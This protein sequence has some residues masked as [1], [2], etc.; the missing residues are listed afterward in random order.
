ML[1]SQADTGST[2]ISQL[3]KRQRLLKRKQALWTARSSRDVE[4]RE[5][6]TYL[7]PRL[8]RFNLEHEQR[9]SSK[10]SLYKQILDSS[11]TRGHRTLAAGLMAGVSS[12]ARP[13]VRL[14]IG[15]KQLAEFGPV[16][17]WLKDVTSLMLAIFA[18][19]NTYRSM[20]SIYEELAAFGTG[21]DLIVDDFEDVLRHHPM[22]A[23][24]YALATDNRGAVSTFV[25]EMAMSV[26]QMVEEFGLAKCSMTVRNAYAAGNYDTLVPVYHMVEPRKDR[27]VRKRD[28]LNM[29]FASIY[30]EAGGDD[31]G[32]TL[33]EGG[34]N[35]FPGLAPRWVV[36][37]TDTWGWSPAMEAIGDIKQLQHEQLRK[38]QGIDYMTQPPLRLPTS[39]KGRGVDLLPGGESY[40]DGAAGAV[41]TMFET[42]LDLE[43]LLL[44]IRDVR[45]RINEA[46]YV[47]LFLMLA[48]D[49]R[50]NI[51]AREI[52]ERHE[53]KLLMLG[54]VLERLHDEMLAPM[55][56]IAFERIMRAGILPPPPEEIQ[57]ADLNIEFI[58]TLAQAQRAVGAGGVDRLLGVIGAVSQVKPDVVD[59]LDADQL[60][61]VYADML[62]VDPSIIVADEQVAVIRED[63]A[64]REQAIQAQAAVP[65]AAAAAKDLAQVKTGEQNA[66]TDIIQAVQGYTTGAVQ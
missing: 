55:I 47:P 32:Q 51:T 53:E 9:S 39:A 42:K 56:D 3:S 4:F 61:D 57:G 27:D 35:R 17:L 11:G 18:K 1:T 36:T 25:R 20:H 2:P 10:Y 15:D 43:H 22:T 46:F 30:V 23:G 44:D 54:P 65:A 16:K 12:P 31:H 13:W 64:K 60:V 14:T 63:R 38:A 48:Q 49:T 8:G 33:R 50:S 24:E 28:N 62:G 26:E 41:E 34:Y 58:S 19:S 40:I 21:L 59:K 29:R 66:A 45:E 37:S 52:A 6:T 7:I 5:V